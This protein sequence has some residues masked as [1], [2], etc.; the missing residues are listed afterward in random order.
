M[1]SAAPYY[2]ASFA[3][4]VFWQPKCNQLSEIKHEDVSDT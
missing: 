1:F 4:Y 2:I 3:S